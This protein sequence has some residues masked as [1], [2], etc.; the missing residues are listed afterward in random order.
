M[1]FNGHD[2]D[3]ERT[4]PLDIGAD[5]NSPTNT[6]AANGTVFVTCAGSGADPYASM[7]SGFTAFSTNF[8]S[9]SAI[10]LYSILTVSPTTFTIDMHQLLADAT[11]PILDTYTITK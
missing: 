9:G 3:Y 4:L 6:T 1:S 11:D 7:M 5:V 10:G 2:H 8:S